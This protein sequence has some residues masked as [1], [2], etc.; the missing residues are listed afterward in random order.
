MANFYLRFVESALR[1]PDSISVEVQRQNENAERHSYRQMREACERVARFLAGR[2]FPPQTRC[3]LL[4]QN[5][6]RWLNAYLGTIAAGA[7]AVPL[8][9]NFNAEQIAKLLK[10]SGSSLLFTDARHRAAARRAVEGTSVELFFLEEDFDALPAA[11]ARPFAPAPASDDDMAVI[12]YTSG[13]T[14]DPKGVMLTHAGLAAEMEAVFRI[15]P[16]TPSD[17]ILGVLPLF[18]VLAQMANLLLP[19]ASGS[20][21]VFLESSGSAELVRALRERRITIFVCVPQFFYLIHERIMREAAARGRLAR[22]LFRALLNLSGHGR[23]FGLNL[24]KVFFRP[25]HRLLGLDMRFL[26]TGGARI[27]P[28]ICRDFASLGFELLHAYG[29]SETTGAVAAT[30]VGQSVPGSVGR[31]MHGVKI[32]I[33]DAKPSEEAG[34]R[35]I[36]EIAVSAPTLMKGY[37]NREGATAEVLKDGWFLTGDLGYQD[38]AGNLFIA[39]RKKEMIVLSSGKNIYPEE[40]EAHYL[41]SPFIKEMCVVGLQS[42]PD[43]P[44]SERLHGVIV[45]NFE[46]LRRRQI[47]NAQEVIRFDV[48]TLSGELPPAKRILS[49]ELW[50]EDLPRTTTRKLK[51]FEVAKRARGAA[52]SAKPAAREFSTEERDWAERPQVASALKII[53]SFIKNSND[54]RGQIHPK[55]NIELD[56]GLDSL[57]RVELLAALQRELGAGAPENWSAVQVFTVR[58]LVDAVIARIGSAGARGAG[59]TWDAILGDGT[60]EPE[61]LAITEARPVTDRAWSLFFLIINIL[62][63]IFYDLKVSGLEKLPK[64]GPFILCPN[65]QSFLD[66]PVL[67]SVLPFA[68]ARRLFYVGTSDIFGAGILRRVARTL[69]LI[70]IDPD[71][72]MISAMKAGAYGLSQGRVLVLF[73]EGERSIDG[74]PKT[75]K[76]GAAILSAHLRVPI[77]PAALEGFYDAWPRGKGLRR[78]GNLRIVFGGPIFPPDLVEGDAGY[79]AMTAQL[80]ER[81]MTLWSP[82][83]N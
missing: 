25:V 76:K 52:A 36:G 82:L 60:I 44:F 67:I 1:F 13:T 64:T 14:S 66:G 69:R 34:G 29:L 53:G 4:A 61:A 28:D 33:L 70:P 46:V 15:A 50:Q 21:V 11:A 8:D 45:P 72:N 47:V 55:D 56:L 19:L 81:V 80:K 54:K 62:G 51:R 22:S 20:R 38:A 9:T 58:E 26:V 77:V 48:E 27:D 73:P 63:R 10:D 74:T 12:V 59:P 23:R 2:S 41:R 49:Y 24:G 3:A 32:K 75:F 35:A 68:L 65:H 83:H 57:E 37:Y 7:V 43:E 6:P 39:G 18:H 5:G 79:A 17:A 31:P 42:A 30:P 40:I 16:L 71:V 78:S